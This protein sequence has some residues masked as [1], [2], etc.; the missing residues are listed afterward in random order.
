VGATL[1]AFHVSHDF[2]GL[3]SVR[4]LL[5]IRFSIGGV[6]ASLNDRS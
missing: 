6:P 4:M 5:G 1:T 2:H 3:V